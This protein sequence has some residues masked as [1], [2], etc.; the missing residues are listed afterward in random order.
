[1]RSIDL[2]GTWQVTWNEG[3]HGPQSIEA[4]LQM[5]LF[6]ILHGYECKVPLELHLAMQEKGLVEDLNYGI[7][8][9]KARWVAEK[10]WLYVKRFMGAG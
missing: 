9:L 10:Y 8:T 1:L 3:G 7:N 6:W 2:S 4:Y 5:I